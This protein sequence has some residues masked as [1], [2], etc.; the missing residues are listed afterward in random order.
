MLDN[1]SKY[2]YEI[3]RQKSV[4]KAAKKLF[5][6]QPA[7]S[8]TLKRVEEKL[9][10]HI[11]N[12]KTHPFSLTAEG[13]V[14]IESIEKILSIEEATYGKIHDISNFKGGILKIGLSTALSYY[15]VPKICQSFCRKYPETD[16]SI[17]NSPTDNLYSL[18]EKG[19]ADLIFIPTYNTPE[20][21]ICEN[22]FEE[23]FVVVLRRDYPGIDDLK[24]YALTYED[25]VT[26]SYHA[27]K[28]LDSIEYLKN[29]EFLYNPPSSFIYKKRRLL[30]ADSDVNQHITPMSNHVTLNYN[31]ML[32]G[33]GALLTT[34]ANIAAMRKDD[35]C[36]FFALKSSPENE[37]F[38]MVYCAEEKGVSHKY[39]REFARIAKELF[40]CGNHLNNLNKSE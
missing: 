20:G 26:G 10:A 38:S 7:L 29:V 22:L 35:N 32:A 23:K 3:Y 9:G 6:S 37:R 4:S 24:D 39:I 5:I 31:L 33:M 27:N 40:A 11:F 15:V 21:Y 36:V 8:N 25:I 18:L 12:R 14:Y 28:E 34:D 17:L 30:V 19:E 2:I 13:K 1:T 16:I